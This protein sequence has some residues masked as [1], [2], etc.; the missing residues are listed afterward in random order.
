MRVHTPLSAAG[1]VFS[2]HTYHIS[3]GGREEVCKLTEE[4]PTADQFYR[5]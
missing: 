3:L 2:M 1:Y 4:L 5:V